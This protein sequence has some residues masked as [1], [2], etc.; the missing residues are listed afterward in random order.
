MSQRQ[1]KLHSMTASREIHHVA[2][3]I[4]FWEK[5]DPSVKADL[6]ASAV[7][8]ESSLFFV[9]PIPLTAIALE[10]LTQGNT[11]AGVIVT[12]A[13]HLRT[14]PEFAQHW[15]V[16]L[17]AH[18][19]TVPDA[20]GNKAR[21]VQDGDE[22]AIG[23]TVIHLPGAVL[24]EIALLSHADGGTVIVGDALIN[25]P[26]YGFTFLPDKYCCDP[27]QMR[28]SLQK[29]LTVPFA[30]MLFAHGTAIVSNAHGRLEQL[31]VS[32]S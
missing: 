20:L 2:S 9:D 19:A 15:S 3:G 28:R 27:K 25:F 14:G 30:R 29:L 7:S 23:L 18:A 13:N 5:Y 31:L 16:P 21:T 4:W 8:S 11:P 26:P 6:S 1:P 22:I 17:I 10:E 12:N 32:G 24:G